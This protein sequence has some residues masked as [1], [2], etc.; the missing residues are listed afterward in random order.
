MD[1]L[2]SYCTVLYKMKLLK[3]SFSS[4]KYT[5]TVSNPE[6]ATEV[7][8]VHA[9]EKMNFGSFT[10]L[11]FLFNFTVVFLPASSIPLH[12]PAFSCE[13]EPILSVA[14]DLGFL[15]NCPDTEQSHFSPLSFQ[16]ACTKCS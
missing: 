13:S 15:D 9:L 2:N 6:T 16:S 12:N 1:F 10:V 5:S 3:V 4:C 11:V 8:T 7:F 14:I